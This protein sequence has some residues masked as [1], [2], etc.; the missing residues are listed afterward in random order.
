LLNDAEADSVRAVSA[1]SENPYKMWRIERDYL[2]PLLQSDFF[3]PYNMPR[4]KLPSTY[5]QTGHVE[6]IRYDTIAKSH[7]M[8]GKRILPLMIEQQYAID[9][10]TLDQW[11]MADW[12]LNTLDLDVVRP[13]SHKSFPAGIEL[14]VLDFD[15]VL[16]NNLVHVLD[17]GRE[18]VTCSRSDGMG[19]ERLRARGI[20]VVVLSKETNPVVS[21]RCKKLNLTCYQGVED[22]AAVFETIV[23]EQGATLD[24][25]V[26]VGND[27]NDLECMRLAR[28][29][30][31]WPTR[32]RMS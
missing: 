18:A 25:T 22:K 24:R 7:S 16:T 23:S 32:I 31:P 8:T 3:E 10:D 9:I 19:L 2:S 29:G 28:C 27:V 26:Y 13:S 5:W 12:I 30:L 20:K 11:R 4:Q 21:S 14:L 15:G 17:D 1:S 6:A